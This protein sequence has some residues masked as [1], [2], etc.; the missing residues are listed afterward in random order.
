MR[1]YVVA[2]V[3]AV[4]MAATQ[5]SAQRAAKVDNSAAAPSRSAKLDV[6]IPQ[7]IAYQGKLTD[8]TGRPVDDGSYVMVFSLCAESTGSSFWHETQA[9]ETK[10]GLFNIL[11]GSKVPVSTD[12]I[13]RGGCYLGIRVLPSTQEFRRQRI[14]SVPFAFQ[15]DN[16]DRLQ[17]RDSAA[18]DSVYDR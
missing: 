11:L 12:S 9:V 4:A 1:R 8:S 15:A 18:L 17:G 7:L 13:P 5:A 16:S 6:R 14:V 2:C 3:V 10:G